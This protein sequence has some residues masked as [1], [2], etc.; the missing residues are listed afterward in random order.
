MNI[1][2][3][4]DETAESE[5]KGGSKESLSAMLNKIDEEDLQAILDS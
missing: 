1:T 3:F 5:K 4:M 2:G